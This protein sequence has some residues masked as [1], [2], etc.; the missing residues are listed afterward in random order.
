M[1]Q[2]QAGYDACMQ[3]ANS[4]GA[5]QDAAYQWWLNGQNASYAANQTWIQGVIY[6]EGNYTNPVTGATM[7][8]P[9]APAAGTTYQSPS[10]N[11]M[12]FDPATNTWREVGGVGVFQGQ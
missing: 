1:A 8:L 7:S 9:F 10:G 3:G 2:R 6:G 5:A 11:H 4:V 12:V